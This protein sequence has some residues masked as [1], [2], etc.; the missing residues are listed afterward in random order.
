MK[1]NKGFTLIELLVVVL[2]IGILAAIALPQYFKAV[3]KSRAAEAFTVM[4]SVNHAQ[5]VYH[6]AHPAAFTASFEDLDVDLPG[7]VSGANYTPT[8]NLFSYTLSGTATDVAKITATRTG[9]YTL[10]LGFGD[11]S[12]CCKKLGT[13]DYCATLNIGNTGICQIS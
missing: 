2:I 12:R 6:M 4:G 3:E 1:N 7:S 11:S 13:D 10:A 8:S 5:A 9:K